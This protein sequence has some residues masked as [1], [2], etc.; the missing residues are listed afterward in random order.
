MSADKCGREADGR[1]RSYPVRPRLGVILFGLAL[2]LSVGTIPNLI[3]EALPV[4]TTVPQLKNTWS[5]TS[6]FEVDAPRRHEPIRW[7][8]GAEIPT[9]RFVMYGDY[10]CPYSANLIPIIDRLL[11]Q[12]PNAVSF[13]YRH[14]PL[15]QHDKATLAVAAVEAAGRQ[16]KFWSLHRLLYSQQADWNNLSSS[17]FRDY[18]A[19][20]AADL[21]LNVGSFLAS[22]NR[23]NLLHWKATI[24][25]H[26]QDTPTPI[27][28]ISETPYLL[29]NGVHWTGP[30]TFE[31]LETNIRILEARAETSSMEPV[32]LGSESRI[33]AQV[34]TNLGAFTIELLRDAAPRNVDSFV[35]LAKRG[36][37]NSAPFYRVLPGFL[38][39]TGD[40]TG[41]GLGGTGYTVDAEISDTVQFDRAGLVAM[42]SLADGRFFV[43]LRELHQFDGKFTIFGAVIAG[44]DILESMPERGLGTGLADPFAAWIVTIKIMPDTR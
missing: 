24:R 12:H 3:V 20:A 19:D 25:R 38:V 7:L 29:V 28:V 40:P 39:R 2:M 37:Y 30:E 1:V 32:A 9:V 43:T 15:S 31:A 6:L 44:L 13:E 34:N 35:A 41:T 26:A 10:Q 5:A 11:E 33:L 14:L 27:D 36:W 18:V 8:R 42:E 17:A 23:L 22:V 16:G 21:G 4:W